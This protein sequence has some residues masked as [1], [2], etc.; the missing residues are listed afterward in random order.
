MK[1]TGEGFPHIRLFQ[2]TDDLK[3]IMWFSSTKSIHESQIDLTRTISIDLGQTSDNFKE[4]PLPSLSHLS[5][6]IQV[7]RPK[8]KKTD[9]FDLTA[10]DELEFDLWITGI[11]ALSYHW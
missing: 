8:S 9:C 11:K 4:Y 7:Q 2:L 1:H 6:S 3:R 5:F 10:K